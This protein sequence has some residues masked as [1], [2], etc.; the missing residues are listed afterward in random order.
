M[1]DIKEEAKRQH[2]AKLHKYG[3]SHEDRACGGS[4]K[5]YADGGKVEHDHPHRSKDLHLIKELEH[6]HEKKRAMGGP[7]ADGGGSSKLG[8]GRKGGKKGTSVNIAIGKPGGDGAG[9]MPMPPPA[10][11]V[12][13]APM[14]PR[15]MPPVAAAPGGLP[16]KPGMPGPMKRGGAA[17]KHEHKEHGHKSSHHHHREHRKQ[18][19]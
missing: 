15:P 3:A 2:D 18:S 17:K 5:K 10:A 13:P 12:G 8:R 6:D 1:K 16:P 4:M 11:G 7:I 9:P 14:P 19:H